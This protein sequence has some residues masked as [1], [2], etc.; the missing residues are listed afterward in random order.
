MGIFSK[1]RRNNNNELRE[2]CYGGLFTV[3]KLLL[4]KAGEEEM[5]KFSESSTNI[6]GFLSGHIAHTYS[7]LTD[8]DQMKW[9]PKQSR[10][11]WGTLDSFMESENIYWDRN[12]N[13]LS[14][15]DV[16]FSLEGKSISKAL[17]EEKD[18]DKW[19]SLVEEVAENIKKINAR[20]EIQYGDIRDFIYREYDEDYNEIKLTK[21]D[22]DYA[23]DIEMVYSRN[24]NSR[25]K[26]LVRL[27]HNAEK[28]HIDSC[29][30]MWAHSKSKEEFKKWDDIVGFSFE[31]LEKKGTFAN[32]L[33]IDPSDNFKIDK[34]RS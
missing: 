21:E 4:T 22:A 20:E 14:R 5:K 34:T 18:S 9:S 25:Q 2:K 8:S 29:V 13:H 32:N 17:L 6:R 27:R 11:V 1:K 15:E 28:G 33:K 23:L 24:E 19:M 12:E 16:R 30:Y 3:Y 10:F 31:Y 7:Y 26:A